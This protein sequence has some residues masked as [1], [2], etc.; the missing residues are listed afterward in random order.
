MYVVA[1]SM[2]W[3]LFILA[4][5]VVGSVPFG[6][7]LGLARGIDIRQH[8]SK[9]IGATNAG[10]VLGRPWGYLCFAL[11][12]LKGAAPVA[13]AGWASG[14]MAA[15]PL[16]QPT[17]WLWIGVAVAAVF[18]HMHS[19]FIGFKG[20]KGVATGF[21]VLLGLWGYLTWPA[22]IALAI[23]IATARLTRYVSVSSCIAAASI[24]VSVA[25]FAIAGG[26]GRG[27]SPLDGVR[28]VWPFLVMALFLAVAVI[29]KH[30][31]NFARLRAGTESRIG[32]RL[33]VSKN[34]GGES[35]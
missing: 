21:G 1:R 28:E 7:L 24:P 5:Y 6:L 26:L 18:G 31:A 9:N 32:K 17:A 10:R 12:V 22:L 19:V 4:A 25:A 30:R 35:S 34:D 15:Q 33:N 2:T 16:P 20:G 27:L 23:W 11:D 29:V 14:A 8:G 13:M 3:L